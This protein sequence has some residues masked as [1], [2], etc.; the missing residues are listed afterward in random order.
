MLSMV[1]WG[2]EFKS[3]KPSAHHGGQIQ[4]LNPLCDGPDLAQ[5]SRALNRGSQI[6]SDL[7]LRFTKLGVT[8]GSPGSANSCAYV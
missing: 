7:G 3:F 5:E 8:L 2:Q 4:A 1:S 6:V